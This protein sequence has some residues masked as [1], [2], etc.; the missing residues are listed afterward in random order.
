M[1]K[2]YHTSHYGPG[3]NVLGD[4]IIYPSELTPKIYSLLQRIFL[5]ISVT[6]I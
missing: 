2:E 1:N 6:A 3:D 4:K 5:E